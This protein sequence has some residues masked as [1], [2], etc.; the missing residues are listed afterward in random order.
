MSKGCQ[1]EAFSEEWNQMTKQQ[2]QDATQRIDVLSTTL[3][4][5]NKIINHL[6]QKNNVTPVSDVMTHKITQL[7][8]L[9]GIS[10]GDK[11]DLSIITRLENIVAVEVK[12][13]I[14]NPN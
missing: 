11:G 5:I 1:T 2:Q 8:R 12:G 10:E 4:K 14:S 3:E 13:K 7:E 9:Y 6:F